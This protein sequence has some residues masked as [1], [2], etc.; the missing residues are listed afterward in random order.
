MKEPTTVVLS[1]K[2]VPEGHTRGDKVKEG[3]YYFD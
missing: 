2:G 3:K 1:Q